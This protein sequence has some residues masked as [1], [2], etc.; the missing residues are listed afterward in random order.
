MVL[1]GKNEI[2]ELRRNAFTPYLIFAVYFV[3][4]VPTPLPLPP[5]PQAFP[6]YTIEKH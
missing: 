4:P 2:V 5:P 6:M 3:L 1:R